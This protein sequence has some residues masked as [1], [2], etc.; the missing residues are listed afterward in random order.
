[1]V[2]NVNATGV[3][4]SKVDVTFYLH[5][6]MRYIDVLAYFTLCLFVLEDDGNYHWVGD[7]KAVQRRV[8]LATP[9]FI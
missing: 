6:L 7:G 2:F 8:R 9:C 3:I 4:D 1:M 5:T